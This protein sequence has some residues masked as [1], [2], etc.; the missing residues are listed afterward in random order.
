M[1]NLS[2]I[3]PGDYP[4]PP[5][6]QD[7]QIEVQELLYRCSNDKQIMDYLQ[8][9]PCPYLRKAVTLCFQD[10]W[11]QLEQL[12]DER[13][14]YYDSDSAWRKSWVYLDADIKLIIQKANQEQVLLETANNTDNTQEQKPILTHTKTQTTMP[15]IINGNPQTLNHYEG[16]HYENCT[17]IT[18]TPAPPPAKEKIVEDI[19]PV[20][21]ETRRE[22]VDAA[23]KVD[24][25]AFRS[26]LTI[27]YLNRKDDCQHMLELLTQ[28]G[29][30]KKD[31][32]RMAL[33]LYQ[34]GNVALK[35]EHIT[36]FKQ[37]YGICC[38]LLG[39][40]DEKKSYTPRDLTPNQTT[41]QIQ[42]YL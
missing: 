7:L 42:L 36:T 38:E 35:R 2:Y 17:F 18:T 8:R 11:H 32:A 5:S 39:W 1:S 37:W 14:G 21:E 10:N 3:F 23:H 6:E 9:I 19:V 26:L 29:Y 24:I 15:L 28:P 4:N 12:R 25:D 31:H 40:E 22:A 27:P 33:A 16:A 20:I 30:S 13:T 41:K 34:S